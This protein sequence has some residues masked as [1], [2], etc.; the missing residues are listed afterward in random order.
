MRIAVVTH[1]CGL[2]LK[3]LD[4]F[5]SKSGRN[6]PHQDFHVISM[7]IFTFVPR[8]PFGL[9]AQMNAR[10]ERTLLRWDSQE[11]LLHGSPRRNM[12]PTHGWT[13][14]HGHKSGLPSQHKYYQSDLPAKKHA[15]VVFFRSGWSW[16]GGGRS[17]RGR[18]LQSLQLTRTRVTT[19]LTRRLFW[20]STVASCDVLPS[21]CSH[22]ANEEICSPAD[23]PPRRAQMPSGAAIA[24]SGSPEQ[25]RPL[26]VSSLR[27]QRDFWSWWVSPWL[28]R[29]EEAIT[30][31]E[32]RIIKET[33]M[34]GW[35][36]LQHGPAAAVLTLGAAPHQ[37]NTHTLCSTSVEIAAASAQLFP[38]IKALE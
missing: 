30:A 38:T 15:R 22:L 24:A 29:P 5:P 12:P 31:Y 19:P 37:P 20:G 17:M 25:R 28:Q 10:V 11:A 9:W 33:A 21:C 34:G 27:K 4:Q 14:M 26:C 1:D 7:Q 18:D 23:V 32:N 3:S 13:G 35:C 36:R 6:L 16:H 2:S 8:V